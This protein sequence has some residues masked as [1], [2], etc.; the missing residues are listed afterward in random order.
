MVRHDTVQQATTRPLLGHDTTRQFTIRRS[1]RGW[2]QGHDTKICIIAE[3]GDFGSQ[4][5]GTTLR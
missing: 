2:E 1:A 3:E 5:D 4:Y